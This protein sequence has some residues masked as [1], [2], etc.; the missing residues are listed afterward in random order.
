LQQKKKLMLLRSFI[1][2]IVEVAE[3]FQKKS[4]EALSGRNLTALP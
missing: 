4:T 3:K 1:K 2:Q